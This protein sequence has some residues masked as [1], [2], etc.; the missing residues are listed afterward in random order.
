MIIVLMF[1]SCYTAKKAQRQ[2][3]RANLEF[4]LVTTDFC[5]TNYPVKESVKETIKIIQGKDIVKVDTV[6]VD[7]DSVVS[8]DKIDNKVLIKW[9]TIYRTDTIIKTKI[10]YQENTAK[11][12]NLELKVK[13]RDKSI[14]EKDTKIAQLKSDKKDLISTVMI[15][16]LLLLGTGYLF[17]KK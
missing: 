11:V 13:E 10:V 7:C 6:T 9:K 4:P 8:D 12:T 14:I 5:S 16:T 3:L 15:L 2:V 1:T 17:F